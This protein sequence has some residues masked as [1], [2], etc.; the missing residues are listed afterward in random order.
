MN[1]KQIDDIIANKT[2][3]IVDTREQDKYIKDTFEKNNIKYK[4]QKMNY[5][6]FGIE[7]DGKILPVSVERKGSLNE[8]GINLTK[9]KERFEREMQRCV[10]DNGCMIIMIENDSYKNICEKKYPNNLT[11]KQY[12]ALLHTIYARYNIPFVFI[13]KEYS[14]VFIYNTLK[15]KAREYLKNKE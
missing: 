13:D 5:G 9:G 11:V 14:P 15:R 6:D 3:I 7:V 8:L 1:K 10:D 4:I 12:L 2:Y